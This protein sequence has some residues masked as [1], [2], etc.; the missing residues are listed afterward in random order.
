MAS[1]LIAGRSFE[2]EGPAGDLYAQS[3]QGAADALAPLASLA[4]RVL[5]DRALILDVGANVGLAS[6]ALSAA[7]PQGRVLALE[8]GLRVFP[9]LQA[10]L[11]R[12]DL[13]DRVAAL[14]LAAGSHDGEALFEEPPHNGAAARV[15][16]GTGPVRFPLVPRPITTLSTLTQREAL[17]RVDLIKVDAEGHE[18]HVLAGAAELI[19]R[20]RPVVVLE[21]NLFCLFAFGRANPLDFAHAL[22]TAFD[23]ALLTPDGGEDAAEDNAWRLTAQVMQQHQGVV[24]LV[25]RPKPDACVPPLAELLG[26]MGV[27]N[28][29]AK[30]V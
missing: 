9:F 1:I 24:D 4:G 22:L 16:D 13:G 19:A 17:G 3:L 26:E 28:T 25:L 12:A 10:N 27:A 30:D 15:R 20:D 18:P 5:P 14:P 21:F 6:L 11:A 23:V 29:G 8:P 2:V 7:R